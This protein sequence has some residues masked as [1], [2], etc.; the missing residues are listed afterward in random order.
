MSLSGP[1]P[2]GKVGLQLAAVSW[3]GTLL[4]FFLNPG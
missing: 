4:L 2:I 3:L 1:G